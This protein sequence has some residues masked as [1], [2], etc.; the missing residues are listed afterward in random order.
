MNDLIS[1][2]REYGEDYDPTMITVNVK[3]EL[4][5]L[6]FDRNK[7][8]SMLTEICTHVSN[9]KESAVSESPVNEN[10]NRN[11][12]EDGSEKRVKKA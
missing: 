1:D 2:I 7:V 6:E 4:K 9:M 11:I 10:N 3:T 12:K 5:M 8:Y